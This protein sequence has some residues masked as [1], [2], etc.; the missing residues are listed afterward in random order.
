MN[1]IRLNLKLHNFLI[2]FTFTYA[3]E[4]K[5]PVGF[6]LHKQVKAKASS[7]IPL[8]KRLNQSLKSILVLFECSES[9]M[10][11]GKNNLGL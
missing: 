4:R 7:I 11:H 5:V 10:Q 2:I 3:I 9:L 1:A 8:E 6:E